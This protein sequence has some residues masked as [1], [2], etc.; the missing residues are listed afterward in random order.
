M[1]KISNF[2]L[3]KNIQKKLLEFFVLEVTTRSTADILDIQS[4]LF[5]QKN[6]SHY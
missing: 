6:Q 2:K 5:Y 4:I 3:S 1:A